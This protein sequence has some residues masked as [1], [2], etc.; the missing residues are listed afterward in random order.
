MKR[1][2]DIVRDRLQTYASILVTSIIETL[3]DAVL[4]IKE[5]GSKIEY[6]QIDNEMSTRCNKILSSLERYYI[7]SPDAVIES[8]E[9]I[10]EIVDAYVAL[11]LKPSWIT[12]ERHWLNV[13]FKFLELS[14]EAMV[15]D[16]ELTASTVL[17][18]L[19]LPDQQ[20]VIS[21]QID[22]ISEDDE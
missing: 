15:H 21:Q 1:T 20:P 2:S 14:S 8:R 11:L 4:K 9:M 7:S 13:A 16:N 5:P 3:H 12:N 17:S 6:A 18:R 10:E 19:P 22:D